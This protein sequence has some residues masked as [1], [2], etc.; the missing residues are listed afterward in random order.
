MSSSS[1]RQTTMAKLT[2]ERQVKEKRERK[3][4]KK[5]ERKRLAEAAAENPPGEATGEAA[6]DEVGATPDPAA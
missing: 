5:E 1:K 4:E 6:D 2:R 3:R